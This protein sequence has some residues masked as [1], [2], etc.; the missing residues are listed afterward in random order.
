MVVAVAVVIA[1]AS[2]EVMERLVV[3]EVQ[4]ILVLLVLT[5]SQFAKI[6]KDMI[7]TDLLIMALIGQLLNIMLAQWYI[8]KNGMDGLS[9]PIVTNKRPLF[10]FVRWLKRWR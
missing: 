6:A 5:H 4:T 3:S 9:H 10:A 8:Q 7:L 2:M 1:E